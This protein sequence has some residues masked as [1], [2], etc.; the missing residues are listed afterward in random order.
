MFYQFFV[1]REVVS[2]LE[3][4]AITRAQKRNA[5]KKGPREI[6]EAVNEEYYCIPKNF[7][8]FYS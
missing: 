4:I 6:K 7:L 5:K 3:G 8:N 2:C 1:G